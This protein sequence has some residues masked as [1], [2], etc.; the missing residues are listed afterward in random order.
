MINPC[1]LKLGSQFKRKHMACNNI[2]DI[3][4]QEAGRFGPEVYE[5]IYATTPWVGLVKRGEFPSEIGDTISHLTYERSAPNSVADWDVIDV[6]DQDGQ[7]GGNCLPTAVAVTIGSTTR[8]SQLKRRALEGPDFCAETLRFKFSLRQQLEKIIGVLAG[9]SQI[10]WEQRYRRDYSALTEKKCIVYS[11]YKTT[12][13]TT[14]GTYAAVKATSILD[15]GVLNWAKQKLLRDG[16]GLSAMGRDN[17]APVLTLVCSGETS[18]N[19][20]FRNAEVRQDL[21]WG[22]PSELLKMYGVQR[23]YRGFFHVIDEYPRRFTE[24]GGTYTEVPAFS[25]VAA[26]KGTKS[27]INPA[28]EAAIFEES[29]IFDP[30]VFTSLIPKPITNPAPDFQFDPVTYLGDWRLKNILNRDCN[31]DGNIVYHRGILAHAP[32]PVHPERGFSFIHL[33][34]DPTTVLADCSAALT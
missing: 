19:I 23:D 33:R 6:S 30:T 18:D 24:S 22:Q 5:R 11:A 16:A 20:I 1:G 9:Y 12:G 26:T 2:T 29:H 32:D 21:R 13:Y 34:C 8:T 14:T 7:P 17:G 4:T 27:K 31:P 15:Q 10:E 28:W 25:N 3:L